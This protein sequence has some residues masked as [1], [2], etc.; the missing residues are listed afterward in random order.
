MAVQIEDKCTS[1]C[2]ALAI[3]QVQNQRIKS[4]TTDCL[5][6]ITNAFPKKVQTGQPGLV[7]DLFFQRLHSW[8]FEVE[9]AML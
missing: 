7:A 6:L 2:V 5:P 3:S 8:G 9:T 1:A 4:R